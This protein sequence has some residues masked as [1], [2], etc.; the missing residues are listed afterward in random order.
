M[1]HFLIVGILVVLSTLL[2]RTG[3]RSM[4]DLLPTQASAQAETIDWLFGIH[5]D[6]IAFFFSL[7]VV[8]ILYSVVVFR[9]RKDDDQD[10]A[11]F[12]GNTRLEVVWTIIPL[13]IVLGLALVGAQVLG[14]IERRDPGALEVSVIAQQ[15]SWRFEYPEAGVTSATLV[16]PEDK[17]VLLRL[18]SEDVIHSFWVPEFRVKQDA[19][20]GGEEFVRELRITPNR[21]GVYKLRC[22]ELCG[23]EHYAMLADVLVV[24]ETDFESWLVEQTAECD[25]SSAECGQRWVEQYGCLACHSLDGTEIVGPTWQSLASDLVALDDGSSF[26]VSAE[27]LALSIV[28]PNAQIVE[29]FEPNIMPQNFGEVLTEE[30]INQIVAFLLTLDE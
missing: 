10:G 18:R 16:L 9:R 5:I 14:D 27:Y 21:K 15:W 24:S 30:Q 11:Y 1:V 25:L 6:L 20:P 8:F 19:L 13:G 3:L 28:N 29:G 26:P 2:V 17:Q 4:P 12:E 23:Q 22:A 7:I